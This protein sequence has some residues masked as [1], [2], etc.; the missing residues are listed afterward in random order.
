MTLKQ[1]I[2]GIAAPPPTTEENP[3]ISFK[4]YLQAFNYLPPFFRLVWKTQPTLLLADLVFRLVKSAL[5]MLLLLVGKWIVDEIVLLSQTPQQPDYTY[6]IQL[7]A[8]ELGLTLFNEVLVRIIT[9]LDALLGDLLANTTSIK[10]MEQ[11]ARLDLQQ[12]EDATFYDKLER[13]RRQTIG[14][15]FLFS[16]LFAQLQDLST[17]FFLGVGLVVLSLWLVALLVVAVIPTFFSE[18]YFNRADYSLVRNWTPERRELDYLRLIGASDDTAKEVKIFGLS[19]FL[20][21]RFSLLSRQYYEANKRLTIRRA[22]WGS[23]LS[24][25]AT[26]SYYGAYGYII[27]QTVQGKLSLGDLTFLAGSF[28]RLQNI[29]QGLLARFSQIAQNALSLKDLFDFLAITPTIQSPPQAQAVPLVIQQGFVFENVG[30]KYPN[31]EKWAVR[32]LSFHLAAGEKLALVGENGAG[33][34]TIVKL[35]SRLYDCNEGRILLD[36]IDIKAYDLVALRQLV[37]VIFQD[38]V[39]FHFNVAD[40]IAVGKIAERENEPKIQWSASQSLADSV[41]AKLPAGYH[42]VLGKRFAKGVELSGGEWQ[43]IALAR[44]Y[45]RDAQ[46]L[47]L[48][49]PTA[50]LDARAEFEVFQRFADLTKGKTAVLISHRFSTVRMAD[51]IAVLQHGQLA[52]IGSHEELLAAN[53]LYAELFRLQAQG[54]Q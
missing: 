21:S 15:T 25:L 13:A 32:N 3:P 46:L 2:F 6:L 17:I 44:A 48:D 37:G 19:D 14:R 51:R 39:R 34:T 52:E 4:E 38:F 47:I 20:I 33:K 41:V 50:A 18:T 31:S 42:Q 1:R 8:L 11:A 5:P 23:L 43:K 53:G 10:L 29:V 9:L 22:F 12:F 16:Q 30:F 54:Y 27:W 45:M 35:L 36:G 7:V 28:N 24:S 49:E 26:I 40:N